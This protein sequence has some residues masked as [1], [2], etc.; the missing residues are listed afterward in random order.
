MFTLTPKQKEALAILALPEATNVAFAGGSRSGKTILFCYSMVVR[1]MKCRGS[2]H[3]A[4]RNICRDARAKLGV[5]T[6]PSLH[7]MLGIS[8]SYDKTAGRFTYPGGSTLDLLGLDDAGDHHSRVLGAGYSTILFDECSEIP[9]ESVVFARTRLADK[10][11]LVKRALYSFNPPTRNHYLHKIFVEHVDPID[12]RPLPNPQ[13]YFLFLMNPADNVQNLDDG[14][15]K[16]LDGLPER[17]RIRFRDG[18]WGNPLEG[19][20]WR[21]AWISD[22]RVERIKEELVD[23]VVG[24]DP[25]CGG[26]CS[27]GIVAVARGESGHLYVLADRTSRGT[28]AEWALC[29]VTLAKEVGASRVVCESNQGGNMCTEVLRHANPALDVELVHAG[30]SKMLRAEPVAGLAERGFLHHVGTLVELEDELL[31]FAP[32]QTSPDR[33][34]A[35]VHAVA[36]LTKGG[37]VSPIV[38]GTAGGGIMGMEEDMWTQL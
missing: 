1:A 35:M 19:V 4:V 9:F 15:L 14:Y 38:A 32:G 21:A 3:A 36:S 31:S 29:V 13:N 34:D 22:H 18:L 5:D 7:G 16:S 24:V 12:R 26:S 27:T 33:L 6:L 10:N 8:P 2:R 17:Q 28:P 11:D 37:S 25:A 30:A 23:V 20:L